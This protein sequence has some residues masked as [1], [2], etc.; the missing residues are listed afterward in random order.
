MEKTY[1]AG[2]TVITR[3]NIIDMHKGYFMAL[4]DEKVLKGDIITGF[5][6]WN[7]MI[8]DEHFGKFSVIYGNDIS[9]WKMLNTKSRQ[10]GVKYLQVIRAEVN[11]YSG[12]VEL[13]RGLAGLVKS[14]PYSDFFVYSSD[15]KNKTIEA[16]S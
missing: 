13:N 16:K 11:D 14:F 6:P 2:F 7:V 15:I 12:R 9:L 4:R 3:E 10:K 1:L 8:G 5:H